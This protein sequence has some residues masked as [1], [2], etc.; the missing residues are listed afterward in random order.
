MVTHSRIDKEPPGNTAPVDATKIDSK[1][2]T[3]ESGETGAKKIAT[4]MGDKEFTVV[5]T[6]KKV[7]TNEHHVKSPL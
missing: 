5:D 3:L 4:S 7:G 1:E 2:V 6:V